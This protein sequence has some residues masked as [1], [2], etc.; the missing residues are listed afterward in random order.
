MQSSVEQL[1]WQTSRPS[2]NFVLFS[3]VFRQAYCST[4]CVGGVCMVRSSDATNC[5]LVNFR[6]TLVCWVCSRN[7]SKL[8]HR[9]SRDT[10]LIEE[11][12]CLPGNV[13]FRGF[14][15]S[16]QIYRMEVLSRTVYAIAVAKIS[17]ILTF[18]KTVACRYSEGNHEKHE[19]VWLNINVFCVKIASMS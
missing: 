10:W 18:H 14:W 2:P 12:A 1:G 11:I 13:H 8:K 4:K 15:I 17:I 3:A 6:Q 16:N 7:R 5:T 19:A 9:Y